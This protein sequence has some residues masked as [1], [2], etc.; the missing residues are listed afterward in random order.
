[1]PRGILRK[2]D[3]I[4]LERRRMEKEEREQRA[5]APKRKKSSSREAPD[6]ARGRAAGSAIGKKSPVL[7]SSAPDMVLRGRFFDEGESARWRKAEAERLKREEF[8]RKLNRR[9]LIGC[10]VALVALIVGF[11]LSGLFKA[12]RQMLSA[13]EGSFKDFDFR[14]IRKSSWKETRK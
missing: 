7:G 5:A 13:P 11:V 12:L 6:S 3:G 1:M 10:A 9:M 8:F 2:F 4:P 14:P